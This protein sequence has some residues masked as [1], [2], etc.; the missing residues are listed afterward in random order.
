MRKTKTIE[1]D[2]CDLCGAEKRLINFYDED[3]ELTSD[4]EDVMIRRYCV[5]S[6]IPTPIVTFIVCE[7]CIYDMIKSRLVLEGLR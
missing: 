5:R 6:R 3:G 2:C 7:Q 1:V 4:I